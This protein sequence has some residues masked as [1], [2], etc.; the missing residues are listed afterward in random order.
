MFH[1]WIGFNYL[2]M[3]L[4]IDKTYN[5]KNWVRL[6]NIS[7]QSNSTQHTNTLTKFVASRLNKMCFV[8][9][10]LIIPFPM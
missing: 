9:Y 4:C 1:G 7:T 8:I 6:K 2:K 3:I 5:P 10:N